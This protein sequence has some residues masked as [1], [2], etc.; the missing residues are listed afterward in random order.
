MLATQ[1][2]IQTADD[3]REWFTALHAAGINFHPES[4]FT[5]YVQYGSGERSFTDEEAERMNAA[6]RRCYELVDDPC[7]VALAVFA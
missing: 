5:D 4:D 6:M 1:P 2:N 7:E 3:V